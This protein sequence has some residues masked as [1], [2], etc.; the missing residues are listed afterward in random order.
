MV[1][2]FRGQLSG[3]SIEQKEELQRSSDCIRDCRQ[4]L[5]VLD[6]QHGANVVCRNHIFKNMEMLFFI[7]LRNS[8]VIPIVLCGYCEQMLLILMKIY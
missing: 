4:Y 3:L 1:Q 5:D 8:L 6:A 2:H 7:H